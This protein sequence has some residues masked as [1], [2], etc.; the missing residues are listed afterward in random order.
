MYDNLV[1]FRKKRKNYSPVS[2][3]I[4]QAKPVADQAQGQ[5]QRPWPEQ[6]RTYKKNV[7]VKHE[8]YQ[9]NQLIHSQVKF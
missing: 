7:E 8:C 4:K 3:E 6:G 2:A 9:Q 5:G 1:Q